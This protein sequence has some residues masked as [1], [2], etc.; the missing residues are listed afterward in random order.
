MPYLHWETDKKRKI[1]AETMA[2]VMDERRASDRRQYP[3]LMK[4]LQDRFTDTVEQFRLT[5]GGRAPT[6]LSA[7]SQRSE[8]KVPPFR[9][10]NPVMKSVSRLLSKH[11]KNQAIPGSWRPITKLGNYLLDVAKVYESMDIEPDLRLLIDHLDQKPPL[12]A[13]RTLDQSYHSKLENT[14][15]RDEDQVVYR[16]TKAGHSIDRT[17][18]VVMVDQLWLYILDD[19]QFHSLFFIN[20]APLF[21]E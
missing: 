19:R 14:W 5:Y 13:R 21:D 1:M 6:G 2:K 17:T 11:I 8:P 20:C 3:H 16:G 12:H 10:A 18:R 4:E 7:K 15:R 9:L